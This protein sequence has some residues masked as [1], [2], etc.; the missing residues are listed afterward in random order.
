MD[1]ASQHINIEAARLLFSPAL[2]AASAAV[3]LVLTSGVAG[4]I[5]LRIEAISAGFRAP[6]QHPA[7]ASDTTP[8]E[9]HQAVPQHPTC[10]RSQPKPQP[11]WSAGNA[12]DHLGPISVSPYLRVGPPSFELGAFRPS[13]SRA[14]DERGVTRRHQFARREPD[15]EGLIPIGAPISPERWLRRAVTER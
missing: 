14:R 11:V 12:S 9:S 1:I 6:A 2:I 13:V 5:V 8:E 7:T 4:H 3:W 15:D 10:P